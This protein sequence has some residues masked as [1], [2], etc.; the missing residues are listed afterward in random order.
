MI[1]IRQVTKRFG[2]ITAVNQVSLRVAEGET[3]VLLGTSG[4]GKT[5]LLRMLN[6]LIGPDEGT[7]FINGQNSI[8]PNAETLRRGI[9]YVIQ[10]TGLFPHYTVAQNIAVVPRLLHW[11]G[12]KIRNRTRELVAMLHLPE[13]I[14][15]RFPSQLSGGQQ[16][17]V[18]LA[19]ALAADPPVLLMDEPF[20][21]LDPVTRTGIRREF[22]TLE[23]LR[24][25]TIVLVT[26]DV[27]EAFELGDRICLMDKGAVQ[28]TG[29]PAELLFR[30]ANGF[31]RDFFAGQRLLLQMKT[32]KVKDLITESDLIEAS[33][34]GSQLPEFPS[35]SPLWD[36]LENSI[37][38][39]GETPVVRVESNGRFYA[40]GRGTL[41]RGFYRNLTD[42]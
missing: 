32:L 15:H 33:M 13:T 29:T 11:D 30:P 27:Q 6:R 38:Q 20:G 9:G 36:A 18:G 41:L 35:E 24:S 34:P 5:T 31:V 2:G 4:C 42:L 37:F 1:D 40:V 25:K 17:R 12:E 19:R 21:A 23:A 39:K 10:Q 14:L 16:Q 7:V 8:S 22:K 28:Q 3:L 26:H